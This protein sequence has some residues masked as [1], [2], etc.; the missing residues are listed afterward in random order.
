[1]LIGGDNLP[2]NREGVFRRTILHTIEHLRRHQR[3]AKIARTVQ[4]SGE[5]QERGLIGRDNLPTNEEAVFSGTILH[6][7]LSLIRKAA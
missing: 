4:C 6:T 2:T 7:T 3:H 5:E 1:M